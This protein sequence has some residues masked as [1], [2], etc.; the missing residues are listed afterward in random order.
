[1]FCCFVLFFVV[2][3]SA[4][5]RKFLCLIIGNLFACMCAYVMQRE[6]LY[7]GLCAIFILV[8]VLIYIYKTWIKSGEDA[9]QNVNIMYGKRNRLGG[10]RKTDVLSFYLN[11]KSMV[12][13][14]SVNND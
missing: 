1:M 13:S 8:C 10:L 7:E 3:L 4:Y 2:Y 14:C 11:R 12:N 5:M 9:N 6:C